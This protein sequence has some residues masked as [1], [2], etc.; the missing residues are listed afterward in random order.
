MTTLLAVDPG[1][2]NIGLAL[3][4]LPPSGIWPADL[5]RLTALRKA[6]E[7]STDPDTHLAARFNNIHTAAVSA[8]F[9]YGPLLVI[10]ETP[11]TSADY[12]GQKS[13]RGNTNLLYGALGAIQAA[14]G[15]YCD[16]MG[17]DPLEVV[18]YQRTPNTKK[19]ERH[20]AL[21]DRAGPLPL[22]LPAGPRGG[23][24]PNA[25]DAILCGLSYLDQID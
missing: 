23:I 12:G 8:L 17:L 9:L 19:K 13:R 5:D 22:A 11:S 24:L 3:F 25:Y 20:Q 2:A 14:A 21:R 6:W 1:L 10:I 4:E 16:A 18:H 7:L 15:R